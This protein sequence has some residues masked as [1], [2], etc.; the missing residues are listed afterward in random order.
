M[1]FG[2]FTVLLVNVPSFAAQVPM[3]HDLGRGNM[4]GFNYED[5]YTQQIRKVSETN[6]TS[7]KVSIKLYLKSFLGLLM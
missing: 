6:H 1:G 4:P 2:S 5:L 7:I 3:N